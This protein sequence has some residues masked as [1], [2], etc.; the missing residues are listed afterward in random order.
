MINKTLPVFNKDEQERAHIFLAT[1][2]AM[3]MGR[4]FEEGDWA[5]IYCEAKG[6]PLAGWSNTDIDVIYGHVGIEHK[7]ICRRDKQPIK[8]SLRHDNHASGWDACHKN[9]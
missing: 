7:M 1:Q 9:P 3:M 8:E 5:K 6:I 2:V 4:K